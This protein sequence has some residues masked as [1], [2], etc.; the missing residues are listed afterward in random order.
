MNGKI[1]A[2]HFKCKDFESE[3]Q[4]Q[5]PAQQRL[6]SSK[7]GAASVEWTLLPA[8]FDLNLPASELSPNVVRPLRSE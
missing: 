6:L 2:E 5:A 8:A 3:G 4:T 7:C 1:S